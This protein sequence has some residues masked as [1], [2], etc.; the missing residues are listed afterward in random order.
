MFERM[1]QDNPRRYQVAGLGDWGIT[2]G[3]VY[4]NWEERSFSLSDLPEP[5][6]SYFG[7]DFGYTN[8]PTALFC[9][10]SSSSSWSGPT[11]ERSSSPGRRM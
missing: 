6:R 1:R 7:L 4:E 3:L 11:P 9:G 8:D 10:M 2:E 5:A